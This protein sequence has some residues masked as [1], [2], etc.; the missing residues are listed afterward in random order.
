[1]KQNSEPKK[2]LI[3]FL[4]Y[5]K[6]GNKKQ[7][8]SRTSKTWQSRYDKNAFQGTGLKSFEILSEKQN[9]PTCDFQIK[10]NDEP[11][12]VRLLCETAGHKAD[13]KGE[14]GVFPGSFRAVKN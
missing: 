5:W 12:T 11:H 3:Q 8:F 10:L 14:W 7:M 2:I 13:I 6:K 4:Q 1:M 9:G